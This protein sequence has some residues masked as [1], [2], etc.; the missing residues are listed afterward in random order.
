MAVTYTRPDFTTQLPAVYVENLNKMAQVFERLGAAFAAHQQ[1]VGSP[2]PDMTV[3]ID[4]G[5]IFY[6]DTLSEIS[7]QTVSGFTTP[8]VGQTR[9]DRVVI[10]PTTGVCTR[11]AGT[12]GS[13]S[14]TPSAPAIP[15]DKFPICRIAFTSSDVVITNSM[16]TDERC[17]RTV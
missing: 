2:A 1:D 10:D 4:A 14:P 15:A 17:F 8:T 7:A 3:R 11:V 16:I 12:A 5:P 13:G 6:N 9:V